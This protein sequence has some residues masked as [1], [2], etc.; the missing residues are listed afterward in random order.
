MGEEWDTAADVVL[1]TGASGRWL[2][3]ELQGRGARQ[4][5]FA[6]R[7]VVAVGTEDA[8]ARGVSVEV[9]GLASTCGGSDCA[10][11]YSSSPSVMGVSPI[12]GAADDTLVIY[13]QG[14]ASDCSRNIVGVGGAAC[15]VDSCT[16]SEIT[17][18]LA[19]QAA[20][21][22][23]VTVSITGEGY[24]SS[25]ANFTYT[26]LLSDAS[27]SSVGLGG[28]LAVTITGKG[29]SPAVDGTRASVCSA[30]CR[31]T[32]SSTSE[33]VCVPGAAID[34]AAA[35]GVGGRDRTQDIAVRGGGDDA[36]EDVRT[37]AIS[38]SDAALQFS[39][40]YNSNDDRSLEEVYLRFA[41]VNVAQGSNVSDARLLVKAADNHCKRGVVLYLWAE[42]SDDS[43]A[44]LPGKRG[45]LT[46]R[47]RTGGRME[48]VQEDDW[49]W[50]GESQES[51]DISALV[52]EVN[53]TP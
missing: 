32:S 38:A 5:G 17:C 27:P 49:N 28:G 6:V 22:Y 21:T 36:A 15:A 20:G 26:L 13:G 9:N 3:L 35:S 50:F 45:S 52:N 44:F 10:F 19:A 4:G 1:E 24:A 40:V 14:F 23:P 46:A 53:S 12:S 29:F 41:G 7:D 47:A 30:P 25:E 42:A 2:V 11:A 33:L 48:W 31:V 39:F 34:F 37:G 51:L 8:D 16:T 43:P 18:T